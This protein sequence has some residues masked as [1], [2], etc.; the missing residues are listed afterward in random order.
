MTLGQQSRKQDLCKTL[1]QWSCRSTH[2]PHFASD[3]ALLV[4]VPV[5]RTEWGILELMLWP[6]CQLVPTGRVTCIDRPDVCINQLSTDVTSTEHVPVTSANSSS[7]SLQSLKENLCPLIS[8]INLLF[9]FS[10][11]ILLFI[12]PTKQGYLFSKSITTHSLV[13]YFQQ[14]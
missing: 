2:L 8:E 14:G 1:K 12:F 11:E 13:M 10:G 6:E 3:L 7:C 5:Q 9:P 4:S